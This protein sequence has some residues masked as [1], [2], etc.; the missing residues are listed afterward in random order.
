MID[1]VKKGLAD[2]SNHQSLIH[3]NVDFIVVNA[4]DPEDVISA[5]IQ[6]I[7]EVDSYEVT[8][9]ALKESDKFTERKEVNFVDSR[10]ALG[11]ING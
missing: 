2:N 4:T 9:S 11:D 3:E 10:K 5:G 6:K 8:A 1:T 7:T